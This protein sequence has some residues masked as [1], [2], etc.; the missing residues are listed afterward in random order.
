[1]N[2]AGLR[3]AFAFTILSCCVDTS[4]AAMTKNVL[5]FVCD[6]LR[7]QL[8][9]AYG[10]KFMHTPNFDRLAASSLVFDWAFTNF[11]ICSPSRNSFMS[12][13]MPDTTRVW[14][15]RQDFRAAGLSS[16]GAG[17]DWV[18]LPEHFKQNGYLTLGHGKL[19]HPG[20]PPNWD[21]P[22]SWSQLQ[23]YGKE[24][25]T[26]CDGIANYCPE[27]GP[28][29]SFSDYNTTTEAITTLGTMVK[30]G[31]PF[32][33]G[34][35]MHHPHQNWRTP[36]HLSWEYAGATKGLPPPTVPRMATGAPDIAAAAELDGK[37]QLVLD[38]TN[39]ALANRSQDPD[40][41]AA[42]NGVETVSCPSPGNNT[43]PDYFTQYMRLG[44][45]TA[46]SHS[47]L[48]LG[49]ML[50][51]LDASGKANDTL[52]VVFG[53]HGWELGEHLHYGKHTNTDL[54]VHVPLIMRAPWLPASVGKHTQSFVELVDLYRTISA[55][56]GLP[57]PDAD[58]AGDDFSALF[59]DPTRVLKSEAAAQ[60]S[61]CPGER[62][63]PNVSLPNPDWALNN[64]EDVPVNNITYMGYTLRTPEWRFTEWYDWDR[65]NC[66]A[67]WAAPA[68][69][70]E[71]YSH[72]GHTDPGDFDNYENENV[73]DANPTV[74]SSLRTSLWARYKTK[75]TGC[76]EDQPGSL[77]N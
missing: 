37:T 67:Q 69:A 66:V 77:E 2:Y 31:R 26:S 54:S 27:E 32:F 15:F 22:K 5:F 9:A 43:V 52:V 40:L 53:D 62:N 3:V 21:E 44:Y 68:H 19:Y 73:A 56:A 20:K 38:W 64:C 17:A 1:M 12:G 72:A 71:L 30:D 65:K 74:V 23:P 29:D 34:V 16:A 51:A 25:I 33:L 36:T 11:A 59:T 42:A 47:D 58:V 63:F 48:H 46:V 4:Y 39:A 45:Y 24:H 55:L 10:K 50:D 28:L 61:R 18:T 6:D 41:P 60:Y 75:G 7:P 70:T 76:P 57:E 49:M 35:G 8:N 13:R 14:N